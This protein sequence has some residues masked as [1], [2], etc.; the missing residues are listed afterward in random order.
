VIPAIVQLVGTLPARLRRPRLVSESGTTLQPLPPMIPSFAVLSRQGCRLFAALMPVLG[1]AASG[2]SGSTETS[3]SSSAYTDRGSTTSNVTS[4]DSG[5]STGSYGGYGFGNRYYGPSY[6]NYSVTTYYRPIYFPPAPPALGE[7]IPVNLTRGSLAKFAPPSVLASYVYEPFYAPLSPL[8]FS[9]NLDRRR[10]EKLDGY[11][12]ARTTALEALRTKLD[13]LRNADADARRQALATFADE[14]APALAA[15]EA[16][17]E[18]LRSNFVNGGFFESGSDWNDTRQWRLGDNTRWE[19][20][21]DEIK[22]MTAAAFFQ[23]GLSP[24]QRRL[25]RELAMELSDSLQAPGADISLDAPGPFFYFAPEMARI[26][27][28]VNLPPEVSTKIVAYQA[29]KAA[30]KAELREMLYKQDRTLF[31]FKRV[32]ALKVLAEQQA[33][34]LAALEQLAEEIRVGLAPLPNPASP[35]ALPLPQE[36]SVRISNYLGQKS[37]W[38][39]LM[40]AKLEELRA[41]FPEDRVE[42][43]REG[44]G[45]AI[46]IVGNRRSSAEINARRTTAMANLASFNSVQN[47]RYLALTRDKEVLRADVLKAVTSA[48]SGPGSKS[49]DQ[50]LRQYAYAFG[51]QERWERYREYEIATLQPGL[52]AAQRRLLFGAAMEKLDLPLNTRF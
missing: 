24:A 41:E 44:M 8:L 19:S 5:F 22:V 30:L 12:A 23:D 47:D 32:A 51:Q 7:P 33:G 25:L 14:Q 21:A 27:L 15:L 3:S 16:T 13:S 10:R 2:T 6:S 34:R 40:Q 28:P 49:I 29:Q 17:A 18:E 35:P 50:L 46:Q 20:T 9:E 1:L 52:S 11:R 36:L 48:L 37:E 38:Q 31:D 45:L 43:V 42:Y 26:R 4:Y 39:R